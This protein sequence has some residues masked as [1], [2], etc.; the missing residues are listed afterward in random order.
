MVLIMDNTQVKRLGPGLARGGHQRKTIRVA[1]LAG[2]EFFMRL[3]QLI[4]G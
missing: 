3:N 2:M 4:A 1:Y